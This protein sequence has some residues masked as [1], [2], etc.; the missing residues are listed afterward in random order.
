MY[1]RGWEGLKKLTGNIYDGF[2]CAPDILKAVYERTVLYV[3]VHGFIPVPQGIKEATRQG[4]V[5][6]IH[7]TA[8]VQAQVPGSLQMA[9]TGA[10]HYQGN[11]FD[12]KYVTEGEGIQFN[13]KYDERGNVKAVLAQKLV[14]GTWF[15]ALPGYVDCVFNTSNHVPLRFNDVSFELTPDLIAAFEPGAETRPSKTPYT[16]V[17]TEEG[18][19]VVKV[20]SADVP[21]KWIQGPQEFFFNQ[22]N[23]LALY[24]GLL[25]QT[26]IESLVAGLSVQAGQIIKESNASVPGLAQ[27]SLVYGLPEQL[28]VKAASFGRQ[29]SH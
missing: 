8:F 5:S 10:G 2:I 13:I 17:M 24:Q 4:K 9:N 27:D 25:S 6:T 20:T 23:L 11:K 1:D 15:M 26:E 21:L 7:E 22:P 16:V 19:R 29:A 14:P 12:L 28:A 3:M 18:L